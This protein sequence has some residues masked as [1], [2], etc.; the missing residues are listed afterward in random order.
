MLAFLDCTELHQ[1]NIS[2]SFG[3]KVTLN[4][5]ALQIA[6][7]SC[8]ASKKDVRERELGYTTHVYIVP[9]K[10]LGICKAEIY[11]SSVPFV[12]SA[13]QLHEM[14]LVSLLHRRATRASQLL[15]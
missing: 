15:C 8:T 2:L 7:G 10:N 4:K 9:S 13:F 11:T 3:R 14:S 6:S 1:T 5:L 12:A